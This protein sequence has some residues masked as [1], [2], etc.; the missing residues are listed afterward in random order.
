MENAGRDKV[1]DR[2]AGWLT[3]RVL[4]RPYHRISSHDAITKP[5]SPPSPRRSPP[6]IPPTLAFDIQGPEGCVRVLIGLTCVNDFVEHIA[7]S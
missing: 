3:C 2:R 5:S 4:R 1:R 7:H 6:P